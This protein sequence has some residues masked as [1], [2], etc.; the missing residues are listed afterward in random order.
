MSSAGH[1]KLSPY[2]HQVLKMCLSDWLGPKW[3]LMGASLEQKQER[4]WTSLRLRND[5]VIK[6]D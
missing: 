5:Y 2:I 6:S 4:V 1:L 3:W